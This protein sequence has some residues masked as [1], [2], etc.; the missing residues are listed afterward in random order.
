MH[1]MS[2]WHSKNRQTKWRHLVQRSKGVFGFSFCTATTLRASERVSMYHSPASIAA[3]NT[4][5]HTSQHSCLPP[6]PPIP[7][8]LR[9]YHM[10]P[11]ILRRRSAPISPTSYKPRRLTHHLHGSSAPE[12]ARVPLR[13]HPHHHTAP[14]PSRVV[15]TSLGLPHDRVHFGIAQALELQGPRCA[16]HVISSPSRA[17]SRRRLVARKTCVQR[18][19]RAR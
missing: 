11:P 2:A 14:P 19:A 3:L 17:L 10:S 8:S 16:M 13:R 4:C 12:A 15:H 5:I 1:Y 7:V 6:P 18:V 9:P